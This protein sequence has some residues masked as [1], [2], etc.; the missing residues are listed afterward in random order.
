MRHM[1]RLILAV[2][3]IQLF[4]ACADDGTIRKRD[5]GMVAGGAAGGVAG[6]AIGGNDPAGRVMGTIA[7]VIIGAAVGGYLGSLWDDY[8]RK[9]AAYALETSR[10]NRPT[11]WRNP[12]TGSS[13]TFE[14]TR[15][16]YDHDT[17]CREYT[18]TIYIDGKKQVG[19]GTACRQAD[20]TWRI[21][22]AN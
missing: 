14:P 2:F 5:V 13:N 18:Q 21:T 9:Q 20:G 4:A 3:C 8:D 12:N 7:G 10:D 15:T 19:R 11:Q 22:N 6:G 1:I 16:Y 17:P